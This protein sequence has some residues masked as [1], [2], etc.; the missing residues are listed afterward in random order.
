MKLCLSFGGDL[1]AY[2]LAMAQQMGVKYAMA[3]LPFG[4]PYLNGQRPWDYE[5]MMRMQQHFRDNGLEILVIE[6]APPMEKARPVWSNASCPALPI[7]SR[8]AS[9][10]NRSSALL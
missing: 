2:K 3:S 1:P 9:S 6:S 10:P 4:A 5:P 7:S 8:P